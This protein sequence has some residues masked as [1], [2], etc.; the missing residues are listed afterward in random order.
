MRSP[1]WTLITRATTSTGAAAVSLNCQ[2][3]MK[4]ASTL[5]GAFSQS[6][7]GI[8]RRAKSALIR[9][10]MPCVICFRLPL[11]NTLVR[12]VTFLRTR[13]GGCG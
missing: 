11:R 3:L 5:T 4:P 1:F 6:K 10:G 2:I 9:L 8:R 13:P 7:K 12:P